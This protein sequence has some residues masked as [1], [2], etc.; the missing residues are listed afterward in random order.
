MKPFQMGEKKWS[1]GIV[2]NRFDDRSYEVEVGDTV[3]RRNRVHW[4]KTPECLSSEPTRVISDSDVGGA[5]MIE[6]LVEGMGLQL[7]PEKKHWAPGNWI[8][9]KLQVQGWTMPYKGQH[10][11][12]AADTTRVRVSLTWRTGHGESVKTMLCYA[13]WRKNISIFFFG[14]GYYFWLQGIHLISSIR[15]SSSNV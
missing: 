7:D 9:V 1:K 10:W 6:N 5:Q 8:Q 15:L 13:H 3:Y 12:V 14:F 2:T 11:S 4:K